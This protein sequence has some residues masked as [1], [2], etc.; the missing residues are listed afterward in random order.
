[1][2]PARRQAAVWGLLAV[3]AI[4]GL[5]LPSALV[6]RLGEVGEGLETG[7]GRPDLWLTALRLFQHFPLLGTGLGTFGELSVLTQPPA[8]RGQ[9]VHAHSDLME[10]LAETGV[11]GVNL[12]LAAAGLLAIHVLRRTKATRRARPTL[13]PCGPASTPPAL[14]IPPPVGFHLRP[15]AP[16]AWSAPLG[17]AGSVA[18]AGARGQPA[19]GYPLP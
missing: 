10:F 12:L 16:A 17:G 8:V 5:A 15:P 18:T 3:L 14:S 2:P 6:Q 13:L 11:V 1:A 19:L 4:L 7:G 9:L